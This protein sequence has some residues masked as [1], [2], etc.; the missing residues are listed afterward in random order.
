MRAAG[1]LR[2]IKWDD[3]LDDEFDLSGDATGWGLNLSSNL[4]AGKNDVDPPAVRV[5]RGHPELHERLARGH[6]HRQQPVAT[7]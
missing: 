6:R 3:L 2:L 7:R 5:R 4:K 1:M